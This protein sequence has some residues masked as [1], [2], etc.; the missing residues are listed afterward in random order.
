MEE[1][2]ETGEENLDI[3]HFG[4]RKESGGGGWMKGNP[5]KALT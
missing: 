5:D 1:Q 3:Y 2:R 4:K